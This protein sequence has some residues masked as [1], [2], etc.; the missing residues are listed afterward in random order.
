MCSLKRRKIYSPLSPTKKAPT[1]L[2]MTDVFWWGWTFLDLEQA[3]HVVIN[4]KWKSICIR[5][6]RHTSPRAQWNQIDT[7]AGGT[8]WQKR[9][10][11]F[12]HVIFYIC[13]HAHSIKIIFSNIRDFLCLISSE[14]SCILLTSYGDDLWCLWK[15][16][17][18]IYVPVS[19]NFQ[20][21]LLYQ[22]SSHQNK[23]GW[24]NSCGWRATNQK[25]SY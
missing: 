7:R 8:E 4:E 21:P 19:Q 13:L 18:F 22:H 24:R 1:C 15:A 12:R 11:H 14:S 3:R 20:F 5:V 16:T 9:M 25:L 23:A 17:I 10:R 2:T 6:C